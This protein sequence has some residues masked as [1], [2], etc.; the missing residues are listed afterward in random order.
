MQLL[1][2]PVL[3][4]GLLFLVKT[5][6]TPVCTRAGTGSGQVFSSSDPNSGFCNVGKVPANNS[7]SIHARALDGRKEVIKTELYLY[8]PQWPDERG[9]SEDFAVKFYDAAQMILPLLVPVHPKARRLNLPENLAFDV[10]EFLYYGFYS[11]NGN[12]DEF[13]LSVHLYH[14]DEV[15][16]ISIRFDQNGFFESQSLRAE[17]LSGHADSPDGN[18]CFRFRDG[19]YQVPGP[20]M[21]SIVFPQLEFTKVTAVKTIEPYDIIK[22]TFEKDRKSSRSKKLLQKVKGKMGGRGGAGPSGS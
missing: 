17:D 18:T 21:R 3:F 8:A 20:M 2:R 22:F 14:N 10:T 13:K 11:S 15:I 9:I 1:L 7:P 5:F 19:F 16:Y 12:T 6:A 4:I